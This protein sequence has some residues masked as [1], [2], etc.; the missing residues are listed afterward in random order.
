VV[1]LA[2]P[3]AAIGRVA[4]EIVPALRSGAMVVCLDPA[5]PY[6]GEL[7][8]RDDV[9]YFVTHPCHP[10]VV[11]EYVPGQE[12]DP[13]ARMD[14]F[15]GV[16]RQHIVCALMQG[17]EE[18]YARGEQLARAMFAPVMNAH[19]IT[20]EQ[21]AILEPAMAE[22]V[23]LTCMG[24]IREAMDEAIRRGVPAGAARDFLLGHINVDIGILFGF[25]DAQVSDGARLAMAR[26]REQIL[27]ADWKRVF[28]PES[29]MRQ[30]QEIVKRTVFVRGGTKQ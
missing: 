21:M 27:Q 12:V 18:D 22:T 26:G 11:A 14:F 19:R 25:I 13:Q 23:V 2:I 6:G 28:E 10:P 15:G 9:A 7:P 20:V 8:Q 29:V 24:V 16:A 17:T 30:V 4:A 1:V 3:D 5:A